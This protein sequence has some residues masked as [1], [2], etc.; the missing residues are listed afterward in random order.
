MTTEQ[1][2]D[3]DTRNAW[4]AEQRK[5]KAKRRTF[6]QV[7]QAI[8]DLYAGRNAYAVV[9]NVEFVEAKAKV[10]NND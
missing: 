6:E 10:A 5:P 4:Q 2:I 7:R 8:V 1:I 3:L 9:A